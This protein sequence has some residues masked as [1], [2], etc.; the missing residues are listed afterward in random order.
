MHNMSGFCSNTTRP[1]FRV[2]DEIP[3]R[4]CLYSSAS[5]T[6]F[7]RV[8]ND[9]ALGVVSRPEGRDRGDEDRGKETRSGDH[10]GARESPRVMPA[11]RF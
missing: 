5:V 9:A 2:D 7:I 6:A 4:P 8:A 11:L 10:G 1:G 3:H